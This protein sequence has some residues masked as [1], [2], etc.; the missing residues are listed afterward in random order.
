MEEEYVN[1]IRLLNDHE[2]E[3]VV[4]G[5][6]AVIVYGYVRYTGDLDILINTSEENAD[7]MLT[8]MLKFGYEPYDFE[9]SDF[10]T[11]PGCI[12]IDR[13]G[14]KIEILTRTLG[15]TFEECYA[16][17]SIVDTMGIPTNFISLPDLIKNKQAVGRPKDLED[18]RNLPKIE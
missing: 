15:V 5:G 17:K 10:M 11:E 3:Y 8:V 2:I 14:G 18:I 7:K 1:F 12:S 6:Y 9:L 16:N 4:I 13:N